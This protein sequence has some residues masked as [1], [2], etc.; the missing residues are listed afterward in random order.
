MRNNK[1]HYSRCCNH[2]EVHAYLNDYKECRI[3][4]NCGKVIPK[5]KKPVFTFKSTEML[6]R[7]RLREQLQGGSFDLYNS[8]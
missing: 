2:K 1:V 6:R 8:M 7:K 3:C 5:T 4:T